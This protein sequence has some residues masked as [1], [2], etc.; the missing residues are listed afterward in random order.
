MVSAETLLELCVATVRK[1]DLDRYLPPTLGFEACCVGDDLALAFRLRHA[2]CVLK[3]QRDPARL[4]K[5]VIR[6]RVLAF[7]HVC[8]HAACVSKSDQDVSY[9]FSL[10]CRES[11]VYHHLCEFYRKIHHL[12]PDVF[13]VGGRVFNH[14][15]KKLYIE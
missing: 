13:S 15:G 6:D 11:V 8:R 7:R 3:R 12:F 10:V 2:E 4:F 1:H 14:F 5:L 9:L